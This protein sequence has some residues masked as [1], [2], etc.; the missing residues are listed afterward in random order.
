MKFDALKRLRGKLAAD[1]PVYGFWVTLESPNISDAA[2]ALGFDWLL[3]DTEHNHL[4]WKEVAEHVRATVR[5]HTVCI[6]R[7]PELNASLVKRA[8]DIGA[9]GVMIPWVETA[10]QVRSALTYA[11]YPP[12]GVRGIGGDRATGF[13]QAMLGH[14]AG[15]NDN[16]FVIPMIETVRTMEN[17]P[18]MLSVPGVEMF[19][20]GP[21]DYSSS[22]GYRGQWEGPG[23]AEQIVTMKDAIR[24]AGK[25]CGLAVT[26]NDN[27]RQRREQGF[28]M[29]SIGTDMGLML[30][31]VKETQQSLGIEAV[32]QPG[33]TVK[34]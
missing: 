11:K 22:A 9:D 7:L 29:L 32:I 24:R 18:E 10:D 34:C 33:F 13:G 2:V 30:R 25:H 31:A 21:A 3:I 8:L 23:V 19:F 16:V 5:S 12:E 17:L 1:Q 4:G 26:S 28:R 14:T 6:V 15:A 27:L 20:F